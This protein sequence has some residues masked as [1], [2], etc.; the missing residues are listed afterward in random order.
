MKND[1][2]KKD[3][4]QV[5]QLWIRFLLR[6][7]G[8]SGDRG[9][10]P[11]RPGEKVRISEFLTARGDSSLLMVLAALAIVSCLPALWGEFVWD[12]FLLT[13]LKAISSW[14]GIW[15]IWFD[16]ASAYLQRDA[17]EGHYWP[18]LY[19]TFWLEHKLWG[20]SPLGYHALNLLLHS[21]NTAIL[22]RLLLRL[23][24]PGAFFAAALFAVHPLHAESVAWVISRKDLLSALF[25]L[26]AFSMWVRFT[27]TPGPRRYTAALALF[28]AALLCKSVAITLPAALLILQWWRKG[29]I[30]PRDLVLVT[31]FFLVG[32]IVGGFDIWFYKTNTA[33]SFD[34]SVYERILIA[35]RA[36]W[37]YLEKL[38]WPANLAVIYPRW[39]I[40][41]ADPLGWVGVCAAIT[42]A[43][44]L[45]IMRRRIGRGPMACALFFAVTLSPT[46][47]FVDYSYM[48]HSF[49]ADRFQY[50]AGIGAIVLFASAA[51][52]AARRLSPVTGGAARG[53]ALA[54]LVL[55]GAVTWNQ[56]GVYK[57]EISLFSHVISF[58]PASWAANQ[59]LGMALLRHNRFEDAEIHL[60]RSLEIFPFNTKAFRNLGEA[61]KGRKRYE[62]S[63]QWYRAAVRAEPDEPLNHLGI[64]TVLLALDRYSEGISSMK[65]ALELGH[66]LSTA[67]RIHALIGQGFRKM[68]RHG[69]ADKHFG[70]AV[71]LGM[72]MSPPDPGV[73]FSRAEDLRERRLYEESLKWY[74]SVIEINSGFALAY[75][76]MGDSLYQLGRYAEAVSSIRRAL[77]LEPDFPMAPTLHYLMAQAS[78]KMRR[79]DYAQDRPEGGM[80]SGSG[81]AGAFFS[82]AEG[83]RERRLYEESLKWYLDT[84]KADPD[85][86]LAYAGMGDSLYRLGRYEEAVSSMERVFEMLPDFPMAPTLHYLTGEALRELGRYADAEGHYRSALR[87]APGFN[88]AASSL[89]ELLMAEERY[90]EALDLYGALERVEPENAMIH[91]QIGIALF[92]TGRTEEA[93]LSFGRAL[94]LDP[95]LESARD[96]RERAL[97]SMEKA[98]EQ[99]Q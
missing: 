10:E 7:V 52:R 64:G 42:L 62:E 95:T 41:T 37:F 53:L 63:L 14:K 18:L 79:T 76:G 69:E 44:A 55:L 77:E 30:A 66:D 96:Y 58:N 74:R 60:R 61:L 49:V 33:L 13:K 21:A 45:W 50:L 48:G 51:A 88:E 70:L 19:T 24:V 20:F 73:V 39:E 65:R 31:P 12:D 84:L 75:A 94:S 85:F 89:A 59:N 32:L 17:V 68:G 99:T 92:K 8:F 11:R 5:S 67:P 4:P 91:S 29:R 40:D 72:E 36:L 28:A 23:E 71:K 86:A 38:F 35:S 2:E 82:R 80:E 9:T 27:E 43:F 90:T 46:L 15:Q 54:L 93:L 34:Y 78:R 97:E 47:G 26:T 3:A 56:T 22:W 1:K 81:E 98:A 6:S 87:A 83:L 57:N 16:P 25:Y